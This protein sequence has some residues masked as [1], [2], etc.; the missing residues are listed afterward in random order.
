[1]PKAKLTD[2]QPIPAEQGGTAQLSDVTPVSDQFSAQ[3]EA[4]FS[5][6]AKN[7]TPQ[8]LGTSLAASIPW[9]KQK[10][11]ATLNWGANKL[12][13]AGGVA[14]GGVGGAVGEAVDP[15]GG[16]V[17]GS[18]VGAGIG[19]GAGE[20][21]RQF[22]E[23][24]DGY[25]QFEKPEDKTLGARVKGVGSEALFQAAGEA[26]GQ[27]LGK[28]MR[29]TFER[30]LKKLYYS[31]GL[32][33]GDPL[34]RG[35]LETVMNDVLATEKQTGK[36]A[37]VGD[38]LGVVN[39]T[40]KDIGQQVDSQL[41]LPFKLANGKVIMLGKADAN[42]TEIINA[43]TA[44]ATADPSIVKMAKLNPAGKEAAYLEHV[45]KAALNFQRQPWTYEELMDRRIK[46]NNELAPLYTLPPG[47]QRVYLLDHPDLAV[48][49]AE[50][51]AIRETVYP[52]MDHLSNM[53]P[54]TTQELQDK[55]GALMRI[56]NQINDHLGNLKTKARQQA[57]APLAEQVNGSGYIT[58]SGK[59]GG[60]I[61]RVTRLIHTPNPE[62]RAD[63]QVKNAFG[64][65]A[66]T[67]LRRV[68]TTPAGSKKSGD[69]ILSLPLRNLLNNYQN[70][71]TAP[72]PKD[73]DDDGP[74]SSVASPKDLKERAKKL[75][76]AG[77]GQVAYAHHAVNPATGH[78]IG[79]RDGVTWYDLQTNQQVA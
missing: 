56:E 12:P 45:R 43:I 58:S 69:E 17:P 48:A 52:Q 79:S 34:G 61:H 11:L 60:S 49:K 4:D 73:D 20:A 63:S 2:A 13:T 1:M 37:T 40:K 71:K 44:K 67:N 47:E 32:S 30:S 38:F 55:R 66:G 3:P 39:Q 77:Q 42:P 31:G 68:I 19:G 46:L 5:A 64:H 27:L 16:G 6:F 21:A 35:D 53:P 22:I 57:G 25:D 75:N 59:P 70:D 9:L 24:R 18:I 10:A 54:G 50:A 62:A 65:G 78:R 23:H 14:G 74:Q 72:K 15:L 29:P 36:A 26:S 41:A 76:P 51:D 33:Y 28:W 7:P 8:T